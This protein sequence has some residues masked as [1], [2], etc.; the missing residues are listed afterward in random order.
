MSPTLVVDIAA[1]GAVGGLG[2]AFLIGLAAAMVHTGSTADAKDRSDDPVVVDAVVTDVT[3]ERGDRDT[4]NIWQ[5]TAKPTIVGVASGHDVVSFFSDP[6]PAPGETLRVRG[7]GDDDLHLEGGRLR[8]QTR[9]AV[10][11]GGA[12]L[13]AG[14]VF[15]FLI[16]MSSRSKLHLLRDGTLGTARLSARSED[17]SGDSTSHVLTFRFVDDKGR[18]RD[19]SERV[20]DPKALLDQEHEPILFDDDDAAAL[21][22]L[23]GHPRVQAGRFTSSRPI[24]SALIT[25][26]VV[27]ALA[28]APAALVGGVVLSL[29]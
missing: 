25:I 26:V 4:D 16:A 17:N 23:P 20:D 22:A 24:G 5:V 19:F 8:P 13:V 27:V 28:V 9:G 1:G 7:T 29:G 10:L 12:M 18:T 3:R 14:L 21:D 11:I 6:A 15:L 2:A